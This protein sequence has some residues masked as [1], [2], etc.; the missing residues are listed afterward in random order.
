MYK[1]ELKLDYSVNT[2]QNGIP[3]IVVA[4]GSS[5][6]MQGTNKQLIELG[7]IPVLIRTLLKFE[8]C[9]SISNIILVVRSE[10]LFHIQM[11]CE[12]YMITKLTDIV[13]GGNSRQESVLKGFSRLADSV[14][15]VLIHDGARPFVD[16]NIISAVADALDKC[17]AVTCAV[18]V[19][20]TIK[21]V[22]GDG[23]VLKTVNRENL[24]SVQTPQGVK[25]ADYLKAIKDVDVASF[26]DDTSIMEAAGY[27]VFVVDG[28]YKNI[29]ITTKEDLII[30]QGFLSEESE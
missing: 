8:N 6:R 17:S 7:G 28:S 5:S 26:T 13:C 4:A 19:K 18:K 23:K 29:K 20:D 12:K 1:T 25:A 30:A 3:V 14:D 9:Q 27:E 22:D 21:Q 2:C 24:V 15:K 11:L 10:D 16:N